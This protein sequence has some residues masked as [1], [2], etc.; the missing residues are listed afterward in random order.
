MYDREPLP[1]WDPLRAPSALWT[2]A[3]DAA[4]CMSPFKGQGANQALLDALQIAKGLAR[5][6]AG[7]G[8]PPTLLGMRC[9]DRRVA[10][11]ALWKAG[12]GHPLTRGHLPGSCF[13]S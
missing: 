1:S 11:G 10:R 4:H 13:V 8:V 5:R 12:G 6:R 9:G 7:V 3:G 2:L